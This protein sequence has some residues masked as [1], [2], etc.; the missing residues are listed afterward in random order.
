MKTFQ[1]VTPK[2]PCKP[3]S[4]LSLLGVTALIVGGLFGAGHSL[5]HAQGGDKGDALAKL[6]EARRQNGVLPLVWNAQLE[7]AAQRH[8]DDMA[9][10][11]FVDEVGSDGTSSR[12]RVEASG[13]AKWPSVR[14]WGE[15]IYAGQTSFD[16]AIGFFMGD[17]VQ[18]HAL[19]N[20]KLREADIGIAKDSVRTYWTV[21]LGSQPNLLP[22][23]IN[24]G[25]PVTKDRQIAVQLTQEDAVPQGDDNAIGQVVEVRISDRSDF[26][27]ADWQPWEPL[28]PFTLDRLSGPKT[29]YVQMRDGAGRTTIGA[30]SIEYDPNSRIAP[31][32]VSP[33]SLPGVPSPSPTVPEPAPSPVSEPALGSIA[34]PLS[35]PTAAAPAQPNATPILPTSTAVDIGKPVLADAGPKTATPRAPSAPAQ[36]TPVHS[37]AVVVLIA[38]TATATSLAFTN[39]T[40]DNDPGAATI[41][42]TPS[43]EAPVSAQSARNSS[44]PDWL[45][46]GY[47]VAQAAIIVIGLALFIRRK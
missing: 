4:L 42:L 39:A 36:K 5:A 18:R 8:S 34:S 17:D 25:A 29:V 9:R 41:V 10:G 47:L 14:V 1:P 23:F 6:N 37:G 31:R 30:S 43:P 32:P 28:V 27:N 19:L 26:G 46:P 33:G 45:L 2:R 21:T 44:L 20:P 40:T 13:Y 38:P 16:E 3:T 22:V 35:S 24:D 11:G 15:S 12:Q 7:K